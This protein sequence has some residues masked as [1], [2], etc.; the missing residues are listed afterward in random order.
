MKALLL[1]LAL[2]LSSSTF[3]AEF[4][5]TIGNTLISSQNGKTTTL[6]WIGNRAFGFDGTTYNKIGNT[7]FKNPDSAAATYNKVGNST[8]GSDG[9]TYNK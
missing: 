2:T 6:N 7:T 5:R 4:Y 8:L 3:A 9:T 1:V